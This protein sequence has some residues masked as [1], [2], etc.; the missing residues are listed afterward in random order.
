MNR[1]LLI[2]ALLLPLLAGETAS[3][4]ADGGNSGS[5]GGG[6]NSGP[7]GGGGNSGPGGGGNSGPGG[8]GGDDNSGPGGGDDDDD[9]YEAREA[10]DSGQAAKLKVVLK[11]VRERFPGQVVDVK[12]RRA[13]GRLTYRVKVL[14][15]AGGL[16]T[17]TVD[18]T[19]GKV[20]RVAGSN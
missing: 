8:G 12:L 18:A 6:G 17:V 1:R 7:G 14:E 3:A 15:T 19:T 20:L 5:G 2:L 11:T 10:V 13:S 4:L 9:Q 16:V